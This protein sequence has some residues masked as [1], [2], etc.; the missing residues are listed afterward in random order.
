M[1]RKSQIQLHS[2]RRNR[3]AYVNHEEDK[4]KLQENYII[5]MQPKIRERQ[6]W[7]AGLYQTDL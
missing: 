4:N 7:E 1:E 5:M 3:T 6:G 2:S